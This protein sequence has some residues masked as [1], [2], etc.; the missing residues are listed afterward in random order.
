MSNIFIVGSINKD[1]VITSE[2]MP[3]LGQTL[4]GSNFFMSNGGKGANQAVAAGKLAMSSNFGIS[5][6][7]IGAVGYDEL[8]SGLISNLS[9]N[10]VNAQFVKK[11]SAKSGVAFIVLVDGDNFIIVD[12]GANN[13]VSFED[14]KNAGISFGDYCVLQQEIPADTVEKG[15]AFL[16]KVGVNIILNPAPARHIPKSLYNGMFSITPNETECEFLT[17]I[18][19]TDN[20]SAIEAVNHFKALGVINPVITLGG[21]G[22]AYDNKVI[23]P[24]DRKSVV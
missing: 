15:I 5:V 13:L 24:P 1:V 3:V 17:G 21:S 4:L 22:V 23:P 6:N 20:K 9:T 11:T 8:A 18:K 2:Q 14:I 16:T 10:G 7:M 19:V 12:P